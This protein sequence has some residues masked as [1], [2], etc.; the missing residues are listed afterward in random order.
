MAI[1]LQNATYIDFE[2]LSFRKTNILVGEGVDAQLAFFDHEG[3]IPAEKIS[4]KLDCSGKYVTHSLAIGHH[5]VYSALA[6][7]MPAP[8]KTPENFVENLEYIW[9]H[10]DQT[11]DK[12]M[13]EASALATAIA[14]AKAGATFV[15][16]HHAS[17]NCL[18]GSLDIIAKAFDQVGISHLLCYEITDRYGSER[19]KTA[20]EVSR[21]Y[22]KNRQGL[23]G[24]HASFTVEQAS[25]DAAV[26][27]MQESGSGIHIHVAED[28]ADQNHCLG[29]YGQRVVHRLDE[30]G[31][32]ESPKSI[33]VHC[34]H[35]D[36][37]E[38]KRLKNKPVFIAQ[39]M[40]SNLKNNVGYFNGKGLSER[41]MLGTD[42]MHSDMIRSAQAAFFVGQRYDEIDYK[43]AYQRLRMVHHY[44][45]S[46]DF[47]GDGANNLMVLDYDSPTEMNEQNLMGH[48]LFGWRSSHVQH[49]I[50]DGQLIL[51]NRSLALVDEEASL[52]FCR[53]QANRLWQKLRN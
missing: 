30:A 45:H 4:K 12:E 43:Q 11:L 44:L 24:L 16:D 48:F 26:Q 50:S 2:K 35:L 51:E 23:V 41:I 53:E 36:E 29:K 34:L 3:E 49:L 1:L 25:L 46:N 5:H 32:L 52:S 21:D 6:R 8:V 22:L 14:C 13:I 9:W 10:I 27:L 20:L 33:L 31:V 38:R 42:G 15:I 39:N 18:E 37:E 28:L 17:P 19:A 40:E 47:K 7:G